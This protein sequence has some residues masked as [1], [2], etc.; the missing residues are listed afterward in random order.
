M[1]AA[2]VSVDLQYC[3]STVLG[4]LNMT[5]I[6]EGLTQVN[7]WQ[8]PPEEISGLFEFPKRQVQT[9]ATTPRPTDTTKDPSSMSLDQSYAHDIEYARYC[10]D[11][12]F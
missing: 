12:K 9:T 7:V 3:T 6:Y 5:S 2:M 8:G 4:H 10:F 1:H 11:P